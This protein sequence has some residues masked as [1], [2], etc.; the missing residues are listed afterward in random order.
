MSCN[1]TCNSYIFLGSLISNN[2][3]NIITKNF[4]FFYVIL[5]VRA[6]MKK[7][8]RSLNIN[9]ECLYNVTM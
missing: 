8:E 6:C 1:A 7:E 3:G 4:A 5:L 9:R 2:K